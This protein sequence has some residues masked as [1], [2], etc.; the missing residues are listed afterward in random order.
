MS[1][2]MVL[3][4]TNINLDLQA[5][6]RSMSSQ[7]VLKPIG[8]RTLWRFCFRSMS[9]QMVLKRAIYSTGNR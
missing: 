4:L 9:S 6:F 8:A 1:S 3:K 7:M 5:G 2:Q